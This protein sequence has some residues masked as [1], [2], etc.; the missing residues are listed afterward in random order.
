MARRVCYHTTF[1]RPRAAGGHERTDFINRSAAE[2]AGIVR[3][4]TKAGWSLDGKRAMLCLSKPERDAKVRVLVE[5]L[6]RG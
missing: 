5:R 6:K 4:L 2:T 1:R 3:D